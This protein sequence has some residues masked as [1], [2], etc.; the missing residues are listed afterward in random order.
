MLIGQSAIR[1]SISLRR[2]ALAVTGAHSD[3]PYFVIRVW[4]MDPSSR[5]V[6]AVCRCLSIQL[7]GKQFPVDKIVAIEPLSLLLAFGF[8][9]VG[10]C[11]SSCEDCLEFE[12]TAPLRQSHVVDTIPLKTG[13]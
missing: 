9:S 6:P 3:S 7:P 13:K 1:Y 5:T 11:D 4:H 12:Q 8:M 10:S 2:A